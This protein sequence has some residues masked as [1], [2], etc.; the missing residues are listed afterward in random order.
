MSIYRHTGDRFRQK[1]PRRSVGLTMG[2][3]VDRR[4]FRNQAPSNSLQRAV[5]V[6]GPTIPSTGVMTRS[7]LEGLRRHFGLW[8]KSP[9]TGPGSHWGNGGV[10]KDATDASLTP[11]LITFLDRIEG[12]NLP[13]VCDTDT[14][15]V[16]WNVSLQN[17]VAD[18]SSL[19]VYNRCVGV[20]TENFHPPQPGLPN[21]PGLAD[22]VARA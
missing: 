19:V 9:S 10:F 8:A 20:I 11:C 13:Q 4:V 17:P 1:R 21:S 18:R 3:C 14:I 16:Q 12:S 7:F 6:F 15:D 5:Q 2:V 22:S